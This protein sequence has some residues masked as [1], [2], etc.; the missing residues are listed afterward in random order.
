MDFGLRVS[1]ELGIH[2]WTYVVSFEV[3]MAQLASWKFLKR[4]EESEVMCIWVL[5]LNSVIANRC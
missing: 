5:N 2:S 4:K 3:P 1:D